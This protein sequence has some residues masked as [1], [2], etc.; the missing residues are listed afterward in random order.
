MKKYVRLY[1]D[2]FDYPYDP[3]YPVQCEICMQ[4]AVEIN[5]IDAR[6]MG[7]RPKN[8]M[9]FIENL[10]GTCRACHVE[11]GD[12]PVFRDMLIA[13]HFQFITLHRPDYAIQTHKMDV[14]PIKTTKI[15]RN[16]I[17]YCGSGKKYKN[18]HGKI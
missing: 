17:C 8:D 13:L 15:Q 12:N 9:D 2:F 11:H 14:G 3:D 4:R 7:G 5:H 18:C 6:K 10:M 1:Y 16:D